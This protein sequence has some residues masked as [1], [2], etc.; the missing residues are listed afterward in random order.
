MTGCVRFLHSLL[1][2]AFFTAFG[3]G[4]LLFSVFLLLTV[5]RPVCP[6]RLKTF[7]AT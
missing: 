5:T 3:L 4:S 7:P 1:C 2:A 6:S